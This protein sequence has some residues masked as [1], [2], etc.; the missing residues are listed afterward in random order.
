MK[1]FFD[2]SIIYRRV[3]LNITGVSASRLR[4]GS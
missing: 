1:Y 3:S 2:F 4:R